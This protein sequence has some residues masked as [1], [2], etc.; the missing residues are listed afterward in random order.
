MFT[1]YSPQV[2]AAD[3]S[4]LA[5]LPRT[6]GVPQVTS[7]LNPGITELPRTGIPAL[8]WAAAAIFPLGLRLLKNKEKSKKIVSPN[9][10]WANRQ[11]QRQ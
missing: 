10:T 5:E 6:G 2:L 1:S 8:A 9:S 3:M 11:M 4:Y 7:Q